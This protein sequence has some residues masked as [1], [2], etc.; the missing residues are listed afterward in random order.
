MSDLPSPAFQISDFLEF[1]LSNWVST[2]FWQSGLRIVLLFLGLFLFLKLLRF[3]HQKL[4]FLPLYRRWYARYE[5]WIEFGVILI[6]SLF[7]ISEA[8][9]LHWGLVLILGGVT[10]LS[11]GMAF[12]DILIN[13]LAYPVVRRAIS[14]SE[15]DDIEILGLSGKLAKKSF[16]HIQLT[17]IYGEQITIPNRKILTDVLLRSE[18]KKSIYH[19]DLEFP[20][21]SIYQDSLG[22][23]LDFLHETVLLSAYRSLERAPEVGVEL[24]N[25]DIWL[26]CVCYTNRK[27]YISAY[28]TFL[29]TELAEKTNLLQPEEELDL[30]KP[31]FKKPFTLEPEWKTRTKWTDH[32]QQPMHS[33]PQEAMSTTDMSTTTPLETHTADL[34][35]MNLEELYEVASSND[36]GLVNAAIQE[37]EKR[38][39]RMVPDTAAPVE[40]ATLALEEMTGSVEVPPSSGTAS[41]R[42]ASPAEV[43][44][45]T[46]GM[47]TSAPS[48]GSSVASDSKE[49]SASSESADTAQSA[50]EPKKEYT[51]DE[52][53]QLNDMDL[54]YEFAMSTNPD[55]ANAAMQAI[56]RMQ[57]EMVMPSTDSSSSESSSEA[58]SSEQ[59]L[60]E[61]TPS[62]E[63]TPEEPVASSLEAQESISGDLTPKEPVASSLEA[64]ESP[65]KIEAVD[66]KPIEPSPEPS[67]K[68]PLDSYSLEEIEQLND[69]DL[70]YEFAMSLN[71]EQAEAAMRAIQRMQLNMVV[72]PEATESTDPPEAP[73]EP[74]TSE[75]PA[76]PET[77]LEPPAEPEPLS[78]EPEVAISPQ[79][80]EMAKEPEVMGVLE[81]PELG[82]EPESIESIETV[83]E[84]ETAEELDAIEE[85]ET[86]EELAGIQSTVEPEMDD[87]KEVPEAI[88]S[89]SLDSYSLE[90]IEQLNDM[91]LLYEFTL[92][93]DAEKA[94]AAMRAIQRMQEKMEQET[95]L[96]SVNQV[97]EARDD[98]VAQEQA[99]FESTTQ[100]TVESSKNEV[101]DESPKQ[102]PSDSPQKVFVENE[103]I[104]IQ[105]AQTLQETPSLSLERHTALVQ[106]LHQA[107]QA[108]RET[109]GLPQ[110]DSPAVERLMQVIEETSVQLT[111]DTPE[112][113][114]AMHFLFNT[115]YHSDPEHKSEG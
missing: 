64:Q 38:R 23:L 75:A 30:S 16:T 57:R 65:S 92:C 29:L 114:E 50:V 45:N 106:E 100:E 18:R 62:G 60:L 115:I 113:Q 19:F 85:L 94:H 89:R 80:S 40:P 17:G 84:L 5:G 105:E 22:L 32:F 109:P 2:S 87:Q 99:T 70:L 37:I 9:N 96:S 81:E 41:T 27:N 79:A 88:S 20:V 112:L 93:L 91:D 25:G 76:E 110:E 108:V 98:E 71:A 67:T 46:S 4:L 34:E 3:L 14:L 33:L 104:I 61:D 90:E 36:T 26:K 74:E 31:L 6:I 107:L 43:S 39:R 44:S 82:K 11:L 111:P 48:A 10:V 28:R 24:K 86:A 49:R 56:E 63:P 102:K 83:E 66:Q 72:A 54:L 77:S 103:V 78:E 1:N 51:P 58:T 47:S 52:I 13:V 55:H 21:P 95:V 59:P 97:V 53:V 68:R 101:A 7:V 73:A 42:E 15:G 69:M 12:Q 8:W 35:K